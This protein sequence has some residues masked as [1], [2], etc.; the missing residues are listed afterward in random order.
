MQRVGGWTLFA[1]LIVT[2]AG[3]PLAAAQS[4]V[5]H[6]E[7][8]SRSDDGRSDADDWKMCRYDRSNEDYDR[9]RSIAAC[10]RL[11]NS[12]RYEGARLARVYRLRGWEHRGAGEEDRSLADLKKAIEINPRFARAWR[13][14]VGILTTQRRYDDALDAAN[15][16][17]DLAP[18]DGAGYLAKAHVLMRLKK[19]DQARSAYEY[20]RMLS[21]DSAR[22]HRVSGWDLY[23]MCAP[24]AA[25]AAFRW[26]LQLE[27]ENAWTMTGIAYALGDLAEYDDALK[28][29]NRA[30]EIQKH[31]TFYTFRGSLYLQEKSVHFDPEAAVRDLEMVIGLDGSKFQANYHLAAAYALQDRPEEA[32]EQLRRGVALRHFR[33]QIRRVVGI[34]LDRGH[35][36]A[37]E[38]ASRML[39]QRRQTGNNMP[40]G[41]QSGS[42]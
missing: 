30:I 16:A 29:I 41:D 4:D 31:A 33:P 40:V 2:F 11:I 10:T 39:K 36:D 20:A 17:V 21:P 8:H 7:T 22:I 25:L 24:A 1:C 13:N 6:P 26:A 35:R 42:K 18:N 14:M 15:A 23:R 9:D 12:G 5:G 32:L 27:P 38:K 3:L 28:F 37:A 34:L 19:F